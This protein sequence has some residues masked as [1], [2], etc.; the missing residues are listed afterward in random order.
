MFRACFAVLAAT[1]ASKS[2]YNVSGYLDMG[3]GDVDILMK[4]CFPKDDANGALGTGTGLYD[5]GS[6]KGQAFSVTQAW[7]VENT[8]LTLWGKKKIGKTT[9]L[10]S[11][12]CEVD[13]EGICSGY[14]SAQ[15]DYY[16]YVS[17][18]FFAQ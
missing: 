9:D 7:L 10:I 2:C 13:E 15:P 11:I 1:A 3:D 16:G 8:V 14:F 6:K 5:D 18:E 4:L 17:L 12:M